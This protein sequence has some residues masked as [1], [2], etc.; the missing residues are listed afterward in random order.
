MESLPRLRAA[1]KSDQAAFLR[2][3]PAQTRT[4][5]QLDIPCPL[6]TLGILEPADGATHVL[7]LFPT[8]EEAKAVQIQMAM[9]GVHGPIVERQWT[10]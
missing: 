7:L 2:Q 1:T 3:Q 4:M 8:F 6:E 10:K 9:R 5:W